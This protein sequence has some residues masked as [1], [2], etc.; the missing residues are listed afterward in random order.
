MQNIRITCFFPFFVIRII[1]LNNSLKT[2]PI[3]KVNFKK[4]I[5]FKYKYYIQ[6]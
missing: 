6:I 1:S 4:A 5:I 2:K 3:F